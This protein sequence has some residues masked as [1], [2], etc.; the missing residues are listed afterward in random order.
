MRPNKVEHP[1]FA[2]CVWQAEQPGRFIERL[3]LLCLLGLHAPKKAFM[4]FPPLQQLAI[5]GGRRLFFRLVASTMYS[6]MQGIRY[7]K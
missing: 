4:S 7:A 1:G 2:L 3:L 5:V 6:G